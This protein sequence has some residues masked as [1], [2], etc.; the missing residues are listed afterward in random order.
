MLV[1]LAMYPIL[2]FMHAR[3]ATREEADMLG[4]EYR[5]YRDTVP[6]FVPKFPSNQPR[7]EIA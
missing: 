3:L 2:V 6:A 7:K 1:T 5:R 4:D